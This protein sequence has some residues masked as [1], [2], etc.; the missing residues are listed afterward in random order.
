MA[1]Y[2]WLG[3]PPRPYVVEYGPS[4]EFKVPK[5][6]G[7]MQTLTPIPPATEFV[8]GED[9]GYDLTDERSIRVMDAD[10]R[11]ERVP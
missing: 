7:T 10:T 11:F 6:N 1:R 8:I 2:I 9:I 3:E 4:L 5:K